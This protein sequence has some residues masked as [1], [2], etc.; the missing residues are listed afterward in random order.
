MSDEVQEVAE[1]K[2]VEIKREVDSVVNSVVVFYINVGQL[3]PHKAEAYVEKWKEVSQDA[4]MLIPSH[5]GILYLP[6]RDG[7]TRMEICH[8]PPK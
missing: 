2:K 3:P 4:L 7:T 8:F 1:V 6:V 5:V